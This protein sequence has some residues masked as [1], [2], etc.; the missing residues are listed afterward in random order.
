MA[1]PKIIIGNWKMYKTIEEA[2]AFIQG[3][4]PQMAA[5]DVEVRLAV[6]FTAIGPACQ[7]AKGSNILIGAQNMHDAAEG[8]FTGEVAASM[9]VDVGAQF[10]LLG[11]SERRLFFG[12]DNLFI[13]KKI[14]RALKDGLQ[15]IL[16]IGETE[17]E[18]DDG[19]A[20]DVLKEQLSK[21]LEGISAKEV[22]TLIVAYEPV[23]AIGTGKNAA[24]AEIE[25]MHETVRRILA[26]LY[27]QKLAEKI[28]ILYGGSVKPANARKI[29]EQPDIDGVLVGGASLSLDSF[30]EIVHYK[31]LANIS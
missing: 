18:R 5:E 11:H 4:V 22:G 14:V 27:S 6:P 28:P 25:Q 24:P 12:E 15:P 31:K 8:S 19:K 2:V 30:V 16:C 13:N 9:L 21:G 20:E 7:A 29:L 1:R 3:L 17:Q 23:W 26:E 10:V